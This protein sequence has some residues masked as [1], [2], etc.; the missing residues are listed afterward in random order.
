MKIALSLGRSAF[1]I[2]LLST[3]GTAL[4]QAAVQ[5]SPAA[6]PDAEDAS[7]NGEI[8]VTAQRRNESLSKTPVAVAVVSGETLAKA[9]VVSEQDL[10]VATPGLSV[11][12][13]LG[14]N[15]LN[16]S[17]R[18]QSQD[19]FSGTRPGV[20]PY[21]NE[22]QIGGS[23]GSSAFYD[24]QSVQVLKG[25]QG[26]LFGRS[27]TGGAVLFTTVKP[28]NEFGGYVSGL[29][30][31]YDAF[32][33]EG[34]V[35]AP[36]AGET[37]MARVA[38]FYSKR[39]GFQR[40]LFDGSREGDYEKYGARVSLS[41]NLGDNL[42]NDFVFDYYR[43][44]SENTVPVLAGI[45]PFSGGAIAPFLPTTLLYSGTATPVAQGTGTFILGNFITPGFLPPGVSPATATPAQLAAAGAAAQAAA[46]VIYPAYFADPHHPTTGVSGELV[47]QQ[48]R[49]PYVINSEGRNAYIATNYIVTNATTLDL[50]ADTQLKNVFGYT[51]L[52]TDNAV[53][54]DGTPYGIE[55]NGPKTGTN[56]LFTKAR[57]IS[58]ELQLLGKAFDGKLSYVAGFYFSDERTTNLAQTTFFDIT[59]APPQVNHHTITNKTYAGYAQGSYQLNDSGLA[60]TLGA[61]YTSEKVG[62]ILLPNDAS[63]GLCGTAGFSCRKS[64]TFNRLSWTIGIQ[65]Q[66]SPELL[67]Y[68][69]SRRAYKSGGFNGYLQPK[70]GFG[71]TGGDEYHSE[72]VTD[73][74]LGMKYQGRLGNMPTRFNIALFHNWVLA[75]QRGAYALVAGNP[76]SFTVN[77]PE[78]KTYGA[79]LEAQFRP[80]E[81]FTFGGNFNYTRARFTNGNVT[82]LG[83]PLVFDRVGD[84]PKYSGAVFA[85]ITV[86]VAGE[87]AATLHGDLYAQSEAFDN[88]RSA[89][90]QGTTLPGYALANFRVGIEDSRAGWSLT[91]NLKNAFNRVYYTGGFP[92]GE[93][94][95]LNVLTPGDRR[96]FTVEARY[97][98]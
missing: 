51:D 84:T 77:V 52:K 60:V 45:F 88:P 41:A 10:R 72:R 75:S 9:H 50:G 55:S 87:I 37:L 29:Y 32:K 47:A 57:Q 94:T 65:N 21:V 53:D 79:E 74:E 38:G 14:S 5:P 68:A 69:A 49:G 13:S 17:L 58:E 22:V 64:D 19:A 70:N 86:P 35:N 18:G 54:V 25:P 48:A 23:G 34:A 76:S 46:G 33:L 78:G 93:I 11:R 20:L 4:A 56:G 61:R 36:I 80:V 6:S 43:S 81:W 44:N 98:F 96:T 3:S 73:A 16:Y 1:A 40:N 62:K 66:V 28:T 24:L 12:S 71:E 85:D 27:A 30:G 83:V 97:K 90:D 39:D 95:Q 26:T 31:N 91:A 42:H 8:I 82:V 7:G 89:N 2:A 59:G 67:I 15:Q 92:I 63:A